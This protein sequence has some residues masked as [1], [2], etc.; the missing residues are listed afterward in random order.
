MRDCGSVRENVTEADDWWCFAWTGEAG[1]EE[2]FVVLSDL[3]DG[4]DFFVEKSRDGVGG[5][6]SLRERVDVDGETTATGE[7]H[8]Y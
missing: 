6:R 4:A 7:H 2:S 8:F 3:E 5:R 1:A